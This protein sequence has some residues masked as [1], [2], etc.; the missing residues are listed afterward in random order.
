MSVLFG[1]GQT[2]RH[3]ENSYGLCSQN[4]IK[5][6]HK[7]RIEKI[8][9]VLYIMRQNSLSKQMKKQYISVKQNYI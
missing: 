6:E 8:H 3:T 5:A 7:I 4:A 9:T 2:K 1:Q